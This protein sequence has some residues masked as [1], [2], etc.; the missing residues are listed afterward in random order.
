MATLSTSAGHGAAAILLALAIAGCGQMKHVLTPEAS[1]PA[2]EVSG[3]AAREPGET[4]SAPEDDRDDGRRATPITR[5]TTITQPGDYRLVR[6]LQVT[7]GDGLVITAS[8]VRLWLGEYRLYGPGNKGGRAIVIDGG[9]DVMVRGGKIE[10]FGFGAVLIDAS[11]CRVRDLA[12]RGGDETADPPNGNPP[13]IGIMLVNSP[14]NHVVG[15]H[16]RGVNLGLFVRGGGSYGNSI[17][18]NAVVGGSHGLLA[19]CYNPAPG[20]D[21]TGPHDDRVKYNF[22]ARF[23]TGVVASTHSAQNIF[24]RN[25]IRYFTSAYVDQNGTNVFERNRAVQIAP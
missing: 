24:A 4:A 2:A 7:Q 25:T 22:L 21:P 9:Q 11:R 14:M 5:P 1:G 13:Q 17:H 10:H 3:P 18:G 23:G 16:L 15:N 19:I 20:A 6:D 8:H 12:I